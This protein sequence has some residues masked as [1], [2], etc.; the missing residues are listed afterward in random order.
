MMNNNSYDANKNDFDTKQS[1]GN[2]GITQASE[3]KPS[4]RKQPKT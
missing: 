1:G 2:G 4:N 3:S